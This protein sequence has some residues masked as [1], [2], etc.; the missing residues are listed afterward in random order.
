VAADTDVDMIVSGTLLRAGDQVRVT[1]Q[2][3]AAA[4]GTLLWSDSA[5][6]RGR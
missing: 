1:S 5:Q 4:T 2:L 6:A 3:T